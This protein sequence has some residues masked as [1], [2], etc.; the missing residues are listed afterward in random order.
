MDSLELKLYYNFLTL[1]LVFKK[2]F[3]NTKGTKVLKNMFPTKNFKK[4][5]EFLICRSNLGLK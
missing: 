4:I 3:D 5:E 1:L 2:I